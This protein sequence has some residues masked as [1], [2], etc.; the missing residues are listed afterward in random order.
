M[1]NLLSLLLLA[2]NLAFA[3]V[4]FLVYKNL[5]NLMVASYMPRSLDGKF[6]KYVS[7]KF[8]FC[9]KGTL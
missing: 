3:L 9:H 8:S 6:I 2:Q 5:M 1:V 7:Y 4:A